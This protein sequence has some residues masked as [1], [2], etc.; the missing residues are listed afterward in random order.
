M[1]KSKDKQGSGFSATKI[2]ASEKNEEIK[3][4]AIPI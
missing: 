2:E 1:K 4:T 3:K